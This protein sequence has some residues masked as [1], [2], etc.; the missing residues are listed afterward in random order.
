MEVD[1]IRKAVTE[2]EKDEHK[3]E[4]R[5]FECSRQG[6]MARDC[7]YKKKQKPFRPKQDPI[8]ELLHTSMVEEVSDEEEEGEIIE[9]EEPQK[10]TIKDI[11]MKTASFTS[12]EREEW[13]HAMQEL[14]VDFQEA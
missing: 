1:V 4:G 12:D 11:A 13:V 6:H 2:K 5:C 7:P 3:K 8:E 14:G 10:F 9:Q